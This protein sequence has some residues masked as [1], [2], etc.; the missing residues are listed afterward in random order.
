[1]TFRPPDQPAMKCGSTSPVAIRNSA[2]A[3]RRSMPIGVPRVAVR[4]RSTCI[5]SSRAKWFSTCTFAITQE[6]PTSSASSSPSLGRCR[7]VATSTVMA[8]G[9]MP[10]AT[11]ASIIGRRNSR[12]GTGRV[13]SQMRMQALFLPRA[14]SES[15]AEQIGLTNAAEIAAR[16]SDSLGITPLRMTVGRTSAGRVTG[17]CPF[18]NNSSIRSSVIVQSPCAPAPL[19]VDTRPGAMSPA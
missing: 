13:M 16:G 10:A 1:M 15:G 12:F 19:C 17:K 2:S 5:A 18:P 9:G 8:L 11:I 14:S 3:K 7:P 4:P 6:S